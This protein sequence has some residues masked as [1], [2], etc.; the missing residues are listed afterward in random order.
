[1]QA[2]P[3]ILMHVWFS[4]HGCN[5]HTSCIH[6][7]V[8]NVCMCVCVCVCVCFVRVEYVYILLSHQLGIHQCSIHETDKKHDSEYFISGCC[9]FSPNVICLSYHFI[10]SSTWA[11]CLLYSTKCCSTWIPGLWQEPVLAIQYSTTTP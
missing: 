11:L 4:G 9:C 3:P 6:V 1:M 10:I 8:C 5:S 7:C 2:T